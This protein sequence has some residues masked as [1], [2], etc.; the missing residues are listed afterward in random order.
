M[1][2]R[3]FLVFALTLVFLVSQAEGTEW[4]SIGKDSLGN[5]F[6]YES[7]TLTKLPTGVIKVWSM[8]VY[9]NEGKKRYIQ[10]W[11]NKG[12]NA[13]SLRKLNHTVDLVE[14]DCSTR[15][16]RIK[17]TSEHSIDGVVLDSSTFTQQP[18]EGWESISPGSSWEGL[19]KAV[20]PPWKK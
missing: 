16:L 9:S 5:E 15:G 10:E 3:I 6:F 18:S 8:E 1:K 19:Y 11:T 13:N 20:C 17:A 12:L 2:K 4:A 7:E 14:I